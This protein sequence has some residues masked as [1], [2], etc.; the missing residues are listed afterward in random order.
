MR[1]I[2]VETWSI[3]G[4]ADGR[5]DLPDGP[6]SAFAGGNGTGKSKLLACLL[7]P[8]SQTIPSPNEG[9]V[10]RVDVT[11]RLTDEERSAIAQLSV[12]ARW[13][14]ADIPQDV[15][16]RTSINPTVGLQRDSSP[17][18]PVLREAWSHPVFSRARPSINV[19]FLPAERR[20]FAPN[21]HGIDLN[22]LSDEIA[23]RS[24]AEPRGAV[25]NFGRLDDSEFENFAKALC[26]AASLPSEGSG[27]TSETAAARWASFKSTVNSLIAPKNLLDLTQEHPDRLRIRT[28]TGSTHE[29]EALS[30]GERQALIVISRVLRAGAGHTLVLIDEPDA[31]LHPS[32]S[33][34]LVKALEDGVGPDGQ[35]IL[36]THSPSILD[37]IPPSCILRLAHEEPPKIVADESERLDLYREAGFRASALT[38]SDLLVIVEGESDSPLL[39]LLIP[40]LG[41]A[42]VREA[43][44]RERV[45]RQVEQ[46][47]PFELPVLGV[48]DRDLLA[49]EPDLT[50]ADRITIWP[51]ADLEAVLLSD[52]L[53]RQIMIDRG[54]IKPE[55]A[56]MASLQTLLDE[57][58]DAQMENVLA[59]IAQ[60]L[61][62][63]SN[64]QWPSPKGH[65]PLDRLRRAVADMEAPQIEEVE[66]AIETARATWDSN[67][68]PD[69][70]SLVRGK[71]VLAMFVSRATE[72][73]SGR[74]LLEAVARDQPRLAGL[75]PFRVKVLMA[76]AK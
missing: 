27:R 58:A 47:A 71:E 12:E 46:L 13:G 41:R 69:R 26:V 42:A 33:Q 3:G 15:V 20:L 74:A 39:N 49:P 72:M 53:A 60:R 52:P 19:L 44:G 66:T 28:P 57:L 21:S 38:Q 2:S 76:L 35:L 32:L 45:L 6:V 1:V 17:N 61:L 4:L 23:A 54:L 67:I 63:Q 10:G 36:A 75:E 16:I 8:W 56:T 29:V 59:E 55:F 31:Y 24:I 65:E 22:Q 73:R 14:E 25:Q 43:G 30:S 34:R 48:V 11:L 18:I 62:R 51:Q 64:W 50:I 9:E 70:W 37:R 68:G 40:E 7:S 5:V